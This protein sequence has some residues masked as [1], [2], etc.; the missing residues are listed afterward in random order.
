MSYSL[1]FFLGPGLPLC[2]GV[3]SVPSALAAERLTPFFLGASVGGPITDVAGVPSGCGVAA[4]ESGAFSPLPLDAGADSVAA[5]SGDALT[6]GVSCAGVSS[7]TASV[8][9]SRRSWSGLTL[10]VTI[11]LGLLPAP[12]FRRG[13]F[14]LLSLIITIR[15]K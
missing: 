3:P 9:S 14:G 6:S 5:E 2:L 15:V 11:M 4:L 12:D 7:F 10:R 13:S 1:G 8:W